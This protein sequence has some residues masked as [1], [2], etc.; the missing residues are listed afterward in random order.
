MQIRNPKFI[1][2]D[3]WI[4]VEIE[5]PIHGWIEYTLDP[6]DTDM[7]I[8]NEALRASIDMIGG[9]APFEPNADKGE[10][11]EWLK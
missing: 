3:G 4:D 2:E 6:F 1:N 9:P 10:I 7:T 5:H 11:P 8:D